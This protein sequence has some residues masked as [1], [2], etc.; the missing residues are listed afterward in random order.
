MSATSA[1]FLTEIIRDLEPTSTCSLQLIRL[2][3]LTATGAWWFPR[4]HDGQGGRSGGP[5]DR[6]RPR[7]ISRSRPTGAPAPGQP[8]PARPLTSL[9]AVA[10]AQ[11]D[12]G[13][14]ATGRR[15]PIG[16][17][18]GGSA[19]ACRAD[20]AGLC[21]TGRGAFRSG[22]LAAP[23]GVGAVSD[24]RSGDRSLVDAVSD[25]LGAR[26]ALAPDRDNRPPDRVSTLHSDYC[27]NT[28]H[29]TLR[30][31]APLLRL[32]GRRAPRPAVN[33]WHVAY[34]DRSRAASV[35]FP[36]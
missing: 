7:H 9:A 21:T 19:G 1:L 35:S 6:N 32:P 4:L 8:R 34:S 5:T 10:E 25:G 31:S 11:P 12:V 28:G 30:P 22:G 15:G 26:A 29:G 3:E 27:T 17:S 24:E 23:G 36:E 2:A 13:T 20:T 14:A 16:S 33:G 18:P